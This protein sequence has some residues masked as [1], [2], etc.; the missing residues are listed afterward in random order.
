LSGAGLA[1]HGEGVAGRDCFRGDLRYIGNREADM[2]ERRAT[3]R[4]GRWLNPSETERR[5][6]T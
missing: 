6:E 5:P 2:V 1:S 3:R 4:A